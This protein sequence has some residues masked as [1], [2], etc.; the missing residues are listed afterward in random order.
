MPTV[1]CSTSADLETWT[2]HE[3]TEGLQ[4]DTLQELDTLS[5]RTLN[6]LYEI[7][8]LHPRTAEVLVRGGKFFPEY[9]TAV[10]AGS[11]LGGSFLKLHGIYVGF[12]MEL[13]R[14]R[15]PI[16]TSPVQSIR[17]VEEESDSHPRSE[18]SS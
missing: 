1:S 6:N 2:K 4:I 12:R 15:D 8:V 14:D 13:H 17:M 9:T 11:S 18:L 16:V 5:V 10:L 7:I 3:W